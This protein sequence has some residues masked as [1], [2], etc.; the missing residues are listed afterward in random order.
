[1][2]DVNGHNKT[3][4]YA[5]CRWS[6][7]AGDPFIF[8][9]YDQTRL[10]AFEVEKKVLMIRQGYRVLETYNDRDRNAYLSRYLSSNGIQSDLLD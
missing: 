10:N 8:L 9:K 7:T 6:V 5:C 4:H 1:M 2:L 3:D